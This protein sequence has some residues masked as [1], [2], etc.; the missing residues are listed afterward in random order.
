MVAIL[1]SDM[2]VSR[3]F[4]FVVLILLVLAGGAYYIV[5][6]PFFNRV[7]A[8]E[9]NPI[10]VYLSKNYTLRLSFSKNLENSIRT[11]CDPSVATSTTETRSTGYPC[12]NQNP[13]HKVVIGWADAR[14][15]YMIT[16]QALGNE[17]LYWRNYGTTKTEDADF[18]C[19]EREDYHN[20]RQAI[21][22]LDCV[23]ITTD[24]EKLFSSL[25][26]FQGENKDVKSFVAVLNTLR[27]SSPQQVELELLA[28]ISNLREPDTKYRIDALSMFGSKVYNDGAG[29][30]STSV[31]SSLEKDGMVGSMSSYTITKDS[32]SGID[33]TVCDAVDQTSCY[34]LYCESL[35]SVWNYSLSK[36]VEP[37]VAEATA[38]E[39]EKKCTDAEPIWDG[40]KCR[41]IT[42]DIISSDSCA[43]PVGGSSCEMKIFWSA[44]SPKSQVE[45][46]RPISSTESMVLAKGKSNTLT[47]VF[48]YQKDPYIVELYDGNQKLNE[49][50]LTTK[51]LE[52]GWDETTKKCVNPLVSTAQISGEYYA[53][54]G[55]LQF[56]CDDADNYAVHYGDTGAV[57]A[58]GTYEGVSRAPLI[59]TGNYSVVCL[60]G[61]HAS[62]P[63]A[64][65]YNAPPPPPSEIFF[66]VTPR[67][68]S[69]DETALLNW[70]I[71]YPRE[72]C[73]VKAKV[74]CKNAS[75]SK[76]QIDYEDIFNQSLQSDFTDK[77]DPDT[78]RPIPTAVN[79]LAP[80]HVDTDWRAVGQ[81]TFSIS[82]T[83][84]ITFD[85]GD[86]KPET[87]R[88]YLRTAK[89]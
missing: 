74:V 25:M 48:L 73:T 51:C 24:G 64:K 28:L 4:I 76:E 2:K 46:R 13:V 9:L 41:P 27:Q 15:K 34:P 1:H 80:G 12:Q 82:Y 43:I 5:T 6:A 57:V 68:I 42:G 89:E 17:Q 14:Q 33:A 10:D 23:T 58:T 16:A 72:T 36:C 32:G 54:P 21:F 59:K 8:E 66:L 37:T 26:F 88:V 18:L 63:V 55:T 50:T 60:R 35:T 29:F 20:Y 45:V 61:E 56:T 38:L 70:N 40:V 44:Q 31:S 79:T 67:T 49:G 7:S 62:T 39:G 11:Y 19:K 71:H 83:T 78:S 75:C 65:Y 84:D 87:K 30:A 22:G 86:G 77:D 53:T 69:K 52:G 81:K 47:Y 3:H 85:C